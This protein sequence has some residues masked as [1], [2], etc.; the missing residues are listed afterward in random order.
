MEEGRKNMGWSADTDKIPYVHRI[1]EDEEACTALIRG[2][3]VMMLGWP[4]QDKESVTERLIRERL[5][6]GKPVIR[7]SE[8]IYREGR[9]KAVSPRGLKAK[10][11][12]HIRYKNAPVYM[13]CAG[14][15]VSGDYNL[16]GAYPGKMFK[17]GYYP[18]LRIYDENKL[19]TLL[20][21]DGQQLR[22]CFASRLIKLKHPEF[23]ITAAEFL[24]E[25]GVDFHIDVVGDGPL[26]T[27]LKIRISER[28]L[29]DTITLHG[30]KTPDEV[31]DIMEKSHVFIFASNYLE[32]WGAVVNEAMNSACAVIASSEAGAVPFL[33]LD[34]IN[35]LTFD[36]CD[37]NEFKKLLMM[38][39]EKIR[40][41][42]RAAYN[43]IVK[44][45]N[46]GCAAER[47]LAFCEDITGGNA[48][49]I[50]KD[51]P[52]SRAEVIKAPGILRTF[53]E[54]NHLE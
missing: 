18:P 11:E 39:G 35:G 15:Y 37:E 38:S 17:W 32:G 44:T 14:A 52:M 1:Y 40:D 3:D 5:D 51:G 41:L 27:E 22:L 36:R 9:W 49:E 29:N 43:T 7:V 47:L 33:I 12:E 6:S 45:W 42:Q 19:E 25:N 34:G 4:G 46:A 24:R 31:R 28:S 23:V 50:P 26:S 16:I 53:K 8:R 21:R 13:L 2:C 30:S 10:Y 54:D 20:Y 48:F